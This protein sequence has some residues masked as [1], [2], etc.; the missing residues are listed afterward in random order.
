[1]YDVHRS[2][3]RDC[4]GFGTGLESAGKEGKEKE[5]EKEREKERE[6]EKDNAETQSTLR[7]AE[8]R[9]PQTCV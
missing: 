5:K 1:M 8:S 7:S 3:A 2:G 9:I 6:K 4:G